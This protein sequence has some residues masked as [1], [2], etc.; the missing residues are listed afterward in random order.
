MEKTNK[1]KIGIF[2]IR[3]IIALSVL[4]V[5]L[6]VLLLLRNS[7]AVCEFFAVTVARFW[8]TLFGGL[9]ANISFSIF[10]LFIAIIV[11]AVVVLLVL[12]IVGLVKKQYRRVLSG[13]LVVALFGVSFGVLYT[14]T[15]GMTYN[16]EEV[17]IAIYSEKQSN[18]LKYD[19]VKNIAEYFVNELNVIGARLPRKVDGSV[20][21]PY[22]FAEL[23]ALLI[24]E[25]AKLDS[26][27]Y[28]SFTPTAKVIVNKSIMSQMHIVGV[29]FAP[30]GEANINPNEGDYRLPF[31]MAHEMAHGKG[32]M[33]E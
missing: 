17:D 15:A 1:T 32:V 27:Y 21:C 12:M 23:N 29:F 5:A 13:A 31:S 19:D 24:E 33:R 10:E 28:N 7:E 14:V 8:I 26:A 9:F 30:T 16:R 18:E 2:F 11:I 3:G 22:T 6:I 25:Y 4:A 20:D